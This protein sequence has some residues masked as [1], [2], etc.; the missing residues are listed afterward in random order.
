MTLKLL[1]IIF[2]E[3]LG[4]HR[5]YSKYDVSRVLWIFCIYF[6]I[7]KQNTCVSARWL[8]TCIRTNGD[9]LLCLCLTTIE[10][11]CFL[12][13]FF[14]EKMIQIVQISQLNA[15]KLQW[16]NRFL[17]DFFSF[18]MELLWKWGFFSPGNHSHLEN[19]T[20][21]YAQFK[22]IKNIWIWITCKLLQINIILV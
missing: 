7:Q 10:L 4:R 11:W 6:P 12:I 9:I 8:I 1:F 22:F 21:T 17:G 14:F 19:C 18:P 3:T 16:Y 5:K 20:F 15:I 13:I 2:I